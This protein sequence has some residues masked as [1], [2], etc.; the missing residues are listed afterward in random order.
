MTTIE[1]GVKKKQKVSKHS[2]R[3]FRAQAVFTKKETFISKPYLCHCYAI[4]QIHS[5]TVLDTAI[6]W[7]Q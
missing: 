1:Y 6:F 7:P 5:Q 4:L 2:L 3:L